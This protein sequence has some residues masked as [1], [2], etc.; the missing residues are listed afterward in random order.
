MDITIRP[1]EPREYDTV[2]ELVAQ[3]Y[4]RDE[5]LDFGEG[6]P[7]LAVLRDVTRR[8]AEAE[9]LVAVDGSGDT[10]LGTV[11][12]ASGGTPWA[13]IARPDEAEF[14]M[15]AV[16]EE[17]RGRGTGEALVRA[18]VQRAR[19]TEGCVRLVLSTQGSM[20]AAHRIYARMGFVR[21]PERDWDPIGGV[22]LLTYALEL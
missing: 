11:T 7:Y 17:A 20:L 15:L 10:V 8:A 21:T 5:L 14:R 16:A 2:G 22:A 4:L 6:D 3:A 13:D 12:F 9:V 18:C 1:A 19:A